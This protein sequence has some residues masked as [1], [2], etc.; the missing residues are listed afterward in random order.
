M[1]ESLITLDYVKKYLNI[2]Y[3]NNNKNCF[4]CS[5]LSYDNI[6]DYY[7]DF[8]LIYEEIHELDGKFYSKE[9]IFGKVF[10]DVCVNNFFCK[11]HNIFD[12]CDKYSRCDKYKENSP[13]CNEKV[14]V[15]FDE[16]L[17]NYK[18][19]FID[20]HFHISYFCDNH[21]KYCEFKY[22]PVQK[23]FIRCK[24]NYIHLDIKFLTYNINLP[25]EL[26]YIILEYFQRVNGCGKH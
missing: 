24:F 9:I 12:K 21:S 19:K 15:S 2:N 23:C 7:D 26:I 20:G 13:E 18:D 11:F 22:N 8:N 5:N 10:C 1:E 16:R 17:E 6:Y 25:V 4:L 14:V 3:Q